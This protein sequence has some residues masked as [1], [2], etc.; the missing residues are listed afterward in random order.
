MNNTIINKLKN[1]LDN[2]E[3]LKKI[4][5]RGWLLMKKYTQNWYAAVFIEKITK[6]LNK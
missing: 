6:I 3:Q 2:K 5:D 4:T 1:Y